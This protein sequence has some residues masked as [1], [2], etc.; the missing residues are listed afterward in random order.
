M[1]WG[2]VSFWLGIR[3]APIPSDQALITFAESI[4]WEPLFGPNYASAFT[5]V[6]GLTI[7]GIGH[8]IALP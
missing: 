5:S 6:Q 2:S 7:E 1:W 4:D 3:S 8:T